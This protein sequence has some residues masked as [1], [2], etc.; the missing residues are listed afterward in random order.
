MDWSKELQSRSEQY[1]PEIR[2]DVGDLRK[3][4]YENGSFK[5]VLSLG[6]IEHVIEGRREMLKECYRNP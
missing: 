4:P 1:D 6:A 3:L 5:S 2:Y